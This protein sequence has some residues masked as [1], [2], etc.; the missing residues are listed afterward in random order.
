[1]AM[2]GYYRYS[3]CRTVEP[4]IQW[5]QRQSKPLRSCSPAD[6]RVALILARTSAPP[7]TSGTSH[8]LT[9]QSSSASRTVGGR[10]SAS[11]AAT[12][13]ARWQNP[14]H[15]VVKSTCVL[16]AKLAVSPSEEERGRCTGRQ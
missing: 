2:N 5:P 14:H 11:C 8:V 12:A 10:A 3:V 13:A 15:S 9:E 16:V 6:R 7:T 4:P 1:M